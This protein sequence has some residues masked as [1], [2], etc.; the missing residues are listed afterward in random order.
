M[1]KMHGQKFL[2][3]DFRFVL[4]ELLGRTV[5]CRENLKDVTKNAGTVEGK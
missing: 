1:R 4:P 3:W 5:Q 2:L